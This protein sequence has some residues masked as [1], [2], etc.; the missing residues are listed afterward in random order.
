MLNVI[1]Y[2]TK[3]FVYDS[4]IRVRVSSNLQI[5]EYI[6][7]L[8]T[9]NQ[10]DYH[11]AVLDCD[12]TFC[13]TFFHDGRL[14]EMENITFQCAVLHTTSTGQRRIRVLNIMARATSQLANIYRMA[15][16]DTILQFSIKRII[17]HIPLTPL[18]TLVQHFY[19]K[20]AQSLA[21]YRKNCAANMPSGQLVLPESLKLLPLYCLTISKSPAFSSGT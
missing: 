20:A 14:A 11:A 15:D 9:P 6:G 8:A 4:I 1:S 7:A 16:L 19:L 18:P 2:L 5:G 10:I 12:Q 13:I 17:A 21:S 3:P